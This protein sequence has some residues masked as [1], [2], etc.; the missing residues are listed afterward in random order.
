M[1]RHVLKRV[2]MDSVAIVNSDDPVMTWMKKEEFDNMCGTGRRD[3]RN[4]KSEL[5]GRSSIAVNHP[6]RSAYGE[7]REYG[8]NCKGSHLSSE[9]EGPKLAISIESCLAEIPCIVGI[10]RYRWAFV[11]KHVEV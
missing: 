11:L 7:E 5:E 10:W 8:V 1:I 4:R 2:S 9:T 6:A 3:W